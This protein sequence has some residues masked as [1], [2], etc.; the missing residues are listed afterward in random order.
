MA[1][2]GSSEE[3]FFQLKSDLKVLFLLNTQKKTNLILNGLRKS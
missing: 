2:H 1:D 3:K